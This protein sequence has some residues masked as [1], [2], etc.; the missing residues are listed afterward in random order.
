MNII[1]DGA[2]LGA[3]YNHAS[4]RT[5]IYRVAYQIVLN[6]IQ[7]PDFEVQ[8]SAFENYSNTRRFILES[9]KKSINIVNSESDFKIETFEKQ[10]FNLL[11]SGSLPQRVLD[12]TWL[13]IK[14]LVR[15]DAIYQPEFLKKAQIIHSPLH[16]FPKSVLEHKHLHKITTIH[17]LA[18]F[19]YPD[20]V[21]P[22]NRHLMQ[23]VIEQNRPESHYICISESTKNDLLEFGKGIK[24][25]QISIINLAA[26]CDLFY[27]IGSSEQDPKI[28]EKY[29]IPNDKPYF[30][31]LSTLEP[32]KNLRRTI[33]A[34]LQ[35]IEQQHEKD[36]NFVLVG[37]KGWDFDEILNEIGDSEYKSQIIVTGF[38]DDKDLATIYSRALF[39]SFVSYYEGFGLPVLE[40]MQCGIPVLTSDVSSLPE[41]AGQAAL[42]VN[43]ADTNAIA[44]AIWKLYN[45]ENLRQQLI[46]KSKGQIEKFSWEK[47]G[48]QHTEL[49]KK[50]IL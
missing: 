28:L 14:E 16:P 21:A 22:R 5:G 25:E 41:V 40:A 13:K 43:P 2:V 47:F 45:S 18:A 49:Y 6:A 30:L 20:F 42:M 15:P 9:F 38:V 46:G 17:D 50:L 7:N 44:D 1:I 27:Q 29:G 26:S 11:K 24:P 12:Y 3:S 4:A 10:L 19:R 48:D 8:I 31:S 39:F 37:S 32:R 35:V 36:L 34:F 33:Q 23:R